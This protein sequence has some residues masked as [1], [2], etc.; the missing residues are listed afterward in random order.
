MVDAFCER[1]ALGTR[2]L[3]LLRVRVKRA[4]LSR[5]VDLGSV[6]RGCCPD[7]QQP[8]HKPAQVCTRACLVVVHYAAWSKAMVD[9]V[10]AEWDSKHQGKCSLSVPGSLA[11]DYNALVGHVNRLLEVS[12]VLRRCR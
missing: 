7:R 6:R 10:R 2:T 5:I 3:D 11:S 12:H 8:L 1:S 4:H 9:H